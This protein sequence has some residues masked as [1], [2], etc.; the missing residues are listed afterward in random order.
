MTMKNCRVAAKE[1]AVSLLEPNL[2]AVNAPRA[3]VRVADEDVVRK[4]A[5]LV[6][7]NQRNGHVV[8]QR[9]T[10]D[11]RGNHSQLRILNRSAS[12][13]HRGHLD[14]PLHVKKGKAVAGLVRQSSPLS[15][16]T[17]R[18]GKKQSVVSQFE[19]HL[20]NMPAG[21]KP[22]VDATAVALHVAKTDLTID[23]GHQGRGNSY[24]FLRLFLVRTSLFC[25]QFASV[26]RL[27]S[28]A[29]QT[30]FQL[31]NCSVG[32]SGLESYAVF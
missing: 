30:I 6:T 13:D 23:S 31:H 32:G 29:P 15:F 17:Y 21:R 7:R 2:H 9:G 24:M 20:K 11:Q 8:R 22:A 12:R 18:P 19:R 1:L 14:L 5:N 10:P 27:Y 3:V 26:L 16:R 25:T 28:L 4:I